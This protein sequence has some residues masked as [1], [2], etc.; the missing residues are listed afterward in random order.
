MQLRYGGG[1][2]DRTEPDGRTRTRCGSASI[3]IHQ[4][5]RRAIPRGVERKAL[6]WVCAVEQGQ[7]ELFHITLDGIPSLPSD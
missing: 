4:R 7:E 2:T 3:C 6:R 1:A 5:N